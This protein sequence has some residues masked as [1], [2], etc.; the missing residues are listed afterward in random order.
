MWVVDEKGNEGKTFFQ[1]KI[2]EQYG[3]HQGCTISLTEA[4]RDIL[5][6]MRGYVDKTTYI[7]L[8]DIS[9]CICLNDIEYNVLEYIKY[10][11]AMCGK[12]NTTKMTLTTPNLI[13]VFSNQY[14]DT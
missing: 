10:I 2:E 1:D 6:Y 3:R 13:F 5:Q 4:T 11:W 8:F 12:F 7:F 14:P 9:N